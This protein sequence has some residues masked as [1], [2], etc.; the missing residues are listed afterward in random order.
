MALNNTPQV[1]QNLNQ[2]QSPIQTNFSVLD[3]AFSINH[4]GYNQSGAGKHN[5]VT[6]PVQPNPP[7]TTVTPTTLANEWAIYT[8]NDTNSNPQI[9]LQGP[10]Q[11]PGNY[12]PVNITGC[13]ANNS[14]WA[15]LPCGI[16]LKWATVS[17]QSNNAVPI[18][19]DGASPD[20]T[21]C[22][23]IQATSLDGAGNANVCP[24]LSNITTAG[25]TV[26]LRQIAGIGTH[27][28]PFNYFAIGLG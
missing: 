4:V 2:T 1:G 19:F 15:R 9:F 28:A 17:A 3:T 24:Q 14:G 5:L 27:L 6:L 26:F 16:L 7:T 12:K 20:F 10:S 23:N 21:A 13:S 11:N 22:F 18:T 8:Q 25:F